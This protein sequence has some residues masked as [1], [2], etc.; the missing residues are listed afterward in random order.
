MVFCKIPRVFKR[1]QFYLKIGSTH[2]NKLAS[3][4]GNTRVYQYKVEIIKTAFVLAYL[5]FSLVA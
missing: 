1:S 3:I 5:E 2:L 4:D